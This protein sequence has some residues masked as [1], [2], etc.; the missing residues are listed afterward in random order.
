VRILFLFIVLLFCTAVKSQSDGTFKAEP[1]TQAQEFPK[2]GTYQI[3]LKPGMDKI[4][5][6]NSTLFEVERI[7]NKTQITYIQYSENVKIK[8]LPQSIISS[9]GFIPVEEYAYE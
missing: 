9:P 8:I 4:E 3:I 5:I 2:K 6:P 1:L 7:R